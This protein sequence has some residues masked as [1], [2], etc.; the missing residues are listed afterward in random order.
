MK[1]RHAA[2]LAL[3][4]W[5]L[6]IY[7]EVECASWITCTTQFFV[8]ETNKSLS[9]CNTETK[10]VE[11]LLAEHAKRC[12]GQYIGQFGTM[13]LD[14][15]DRRSKAPMRF[16]TPSEKETAGCAITATTGPRLKGN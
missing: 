4:G 13:C 7:P 14:T 9:D 15:D 1:P 11:A 12:R 5:Y 6:I 10:K 3:V 16:M 2:A 8:W